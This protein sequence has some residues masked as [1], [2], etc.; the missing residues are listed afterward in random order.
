MLNV[1]FF[2]KRDLNN[3]QNYIICRMSNHKITKLFWKCCYKLV[4]LFYFSF[5]RFLHVRTDRT[6]VILYQAKFLHIQLKKNHPDAEENSYVHLSILNSI[7]RY[8][9]DNKSVLLLVKIRRNNCNLFEF[10]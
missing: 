4:G 6:G 3:A 5:S 1:T 8:N 2:Y 10:E 9:F 7:V